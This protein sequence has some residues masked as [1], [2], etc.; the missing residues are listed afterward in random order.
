MRGKFRELA[1]V[2]LS[3]EGAA[4]VEAA[5]DRIDDWHDVGELTGLLRRHGRA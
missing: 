4:A 5:V 2:V 1:D 3:E